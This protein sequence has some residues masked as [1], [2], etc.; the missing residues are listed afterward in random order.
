MPEKTVPG[1]EVCFGRAAEFDLFLRRVRELGREWG[2]STFLWGPPGSGKTLFLKALVASLEEGG[3]EVFPFFY[4]MPGLKWSLRDFAADFTEAFAAQYLAFRKG[5]SVLA[6]GRG[7]I[8]ER[9]R[10]DGS[11][12]GAFL[13]ME[14]RRRCE[15]KGGRSPAYEAA[16]LPGRF[17]AAAGWKVLTVIDDFSRLGEYEPSA[18]AGWPGETLRSAWAPMI[19]TGRSQG[20]VASVLGR[21]G[22]AGLLEMVKLEPLPGEEAAVML[23][24]LLR[25]AGV[26]MTDALVDE[27]AGLAGGEPH[28]LAAVARSLAG[29]GKIDGPLL[30]RT[31]AGSV[32][33]GEIYQYWMD[34]LAGAFDDLAGRRTALEVLVHCVREED[35]PPALE[36]LS[37]AMLKPREDVEEALS[38]LVEAGLIA[39]D[40]SRVRLAGS[41]T[42]K[43]FVLGLY[44]QEAGGGEREFVSAAL[45]AE[46]FRRAAAVR[47]RR[48][49]EDGR[50]RIRSLLEAWT[51]QQVPKALFQGGAAGERADE[52]DEDTLKRLG[53]GGDVLRLPRVVSSASGHLMPE[54][55]PPG[56]EADAAAWGMQERS[57]AGPKS[58]CWLVRLERGETDEKDVVEFQREASALESAGA[59]GNAGVVGWMIS[60]GGFSAEALSRARRERILTSTVRQVA[61][62]GKFLGREVGEL[63]APAGTSSGRGR[64]LDFEMTIPMVSET[65]LVAAKAVEQMAESMDF[66]AGETGRIKMALVEA[67]INAF[68]HS[69]LEEG[70]VR[71]SFTIERSS[72]M[73]RV[74]NKGRKFAPQRVAGAEAKTEMSK[75]GWGLNLIRELMDDVEF[76]RVDDGVRLVMVK[77]LK[78]KEGNGEQVPDDDGNA[79]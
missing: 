60:A 43:D 38:G 53:D 7:E 29:L 6:A 10:A 55:G 12:G 76:E 16:L 40:C 56:V 18:L 67:C 64:R 35:S 74:E 37:K 39:V 11:D 44:R 57:G 41:S 45:A 78:G 42:L 63:L 51:G 52:R 2:R 28:A 36:G 50:R 1:G 4:S 14:Y 70:K 71:L 22:A 58:V 65:E 61:L 47:M 32:C 30:Y 68:E 5:A 72:L 15:E 73:I 54:S 75:R 21:D 59:L 17:A 66:D 24:S 23:R 27:A 48:E 20:R 19:L 34:I 69:G 13:A 8:E 79:S 33:R 77:H 9:L 25:V 31:Y 49:R 46:K 3:T 26:E 62:L